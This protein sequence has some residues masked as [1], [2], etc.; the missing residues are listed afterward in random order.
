MLCLELQK[1]FLTND[2]LHCTMA[3]KVSIRRLC[4]GYMREEGQ[5]LIMDIPDSIAGIV[6]LFYYRL[7][8]DRS[9]TQFK[10]SEDGLTQTTLEDEGGDRP[11]NR[12]G[13]YLHSPDQF[14]C[15]FSF[16]G[17]HDAIMGGSSGIMIGFVT[18]GF[19]EFY[20]FTAGSSTKCACMAAGNG[21]CIIDKKYFQCSKMRHKNH[22][23]PVAFGHTKNDT[24][25][26]TADMKQKKGKIGIFDIELPDSVA[27]VVSTVEGRTVTVVEHH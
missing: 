26:L 11:A 6:T 1:L 3:S 12:F 9:H 10:V 22:T 20:D 23:N 19:N 7:E 16:E 8:F 4:A 13:E 18:D 25:T 17:G 2:P 27:I 15:T 14:E 5:E 21:W 24:I